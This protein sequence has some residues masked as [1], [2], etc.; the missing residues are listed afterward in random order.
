[1]KKVLFS[2]SSIISK[3]T[4]IFKFQI[5]KNLKVNQQQIHQTLLIINEK[6][7]F[8]EIFWN[9]KKL[10]IIFVMQDAKLSARTFSSSYTDL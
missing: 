3:N 6:F 4:F 2:F 10:P 7:K 8:L 1:M 5:N 9:T